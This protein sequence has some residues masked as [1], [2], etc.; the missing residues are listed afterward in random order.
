MARIGKYA[1]ANLWRAFF[2]FGLSGQLL[3]AVSAVTPT[4]NL[5][6][7]GLPDAAESQRIL[8]QFRESGIAGAYYFDF[9]LRELPRHGDETV[10]RGKLWGSRN[11]QGAV[12]RVVLADAAGHENRLLLQNGPQ[13]AVWRWTA[14]RVVPVEAGDLFAPLVPGVE[15]S[16]FDLQMP[17]L[18]W[19]D[20]QVVSITRIRG[21]PAHA[22]VFRPPAVFAEKNSAFASVRSFFDAQFNAPTQTE[23][24]DK[25]GGVLKTFALLDLKKVGGQYIP[26]SFEVRDETSRNK[27]RLVVTA[28]ALNLDLAER[29]FLPANLGSDPAPVKTERLEP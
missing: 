16:A 28:A 8:T 9:E 26:K 2:V 7:V 24:L 25:D 3:G 27:T 18:F 21:R 5:A 14:G 4:T 11:T 1:P 22:F 19:P 23:L 6:Q 13:A 15:L 17:F 29:W 20:A 12:T 10:L